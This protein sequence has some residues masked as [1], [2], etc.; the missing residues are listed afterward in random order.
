MIL[1]FGSRIWDLLLTPVSALASAINPKSE[2]QNPKSF[3]GYFALTRFGFFQHV[4]AYFF[5]Y[6][7]AVSE[8]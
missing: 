4:S 5:A 8:G 6:N 1:D 2:I 3:N 7:H